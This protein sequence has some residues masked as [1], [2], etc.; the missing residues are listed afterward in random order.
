[1]LF[2][3]L[4]LLAF[5]T[6]AYANQK[7]KET[8]SKE[9]IILRLLNTARFSFICFVLPKELIFKIINDTIKLL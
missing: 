4:T 5:I 8:P 6:A 1:M 7:L 3:A 9:I 2:L